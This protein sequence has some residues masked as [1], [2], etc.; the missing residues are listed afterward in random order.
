[1]R[2]K[3]NR[4]LSDFH[5]LRHEWLHATWFQSTCCIRLEEE[6]CDWKNIYHHFKVN[7][8]K[9]PV[10][11]KLKSTSPR[12]SGGFVFAG[13]SV[14]GRLSVYFTFSTY[15]FTEHNTVWFELPSE[16]NLPQN[17]QAKKAAFYQTWHREVHRHWICNKHLFG[18]IRPD[19]QCD[20]PPAGPWLSVSIVFREEAQRE[21]A[22]S[23]TFY[24]RLAPLT[25]ER[26]SCERGGEK[27]HKCLVF[28]KL[29]RAFNDGFVR[30]ADGRGSE[31]NAGPTNTDCLL[32]GVGWMLVFP[33]H[34]WPLWTFV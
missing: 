12:G 15:P 23:S 8:N 27:M 17:I 24:L 4:R 16:I 11:W 2:Q 1:M 21:P 7:T 28:L 26:K 3:P 32:G 13:C 31:C 29:R 14:W 18:R 5:C 19:F 34:K 33:W 20:V 9:K 22:Q 25:R 30:G 10:S 6:L